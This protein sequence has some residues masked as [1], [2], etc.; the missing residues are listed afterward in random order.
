MSD[1]SDIEEYFAEFGIENP[2]NQNRGLNWCGNAAAVTEFA[3]RL[4][5][6]ARPMARNLAALAFA[7]EWYGRFSG[8]IIFGR[9]GRVMNLC[10][11]RDGGIAGEASFELALS[12]DPADRHYPICCSWASLDAGVVAA[13]GDSIYL[14]RTVENEM[15]LVTLDGFRMTNQL[16]T[17]HLSNSPLLSYNRL[18][19]D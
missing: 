6:G 14:V 17:S 3:D 18:P 16:P 12:R 1:G 19:V 5:M 15:G 8:W 10:R 4:P 7:E 9:Q 11:W 2:F 13:V